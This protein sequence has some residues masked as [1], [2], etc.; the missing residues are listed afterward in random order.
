MRSS[1]A[2]GLDTAKGL[3][4]A[5]QIPLVGVNHMQAHALTP[6]L[7]S[8]LA[9]VPG[10]KSSKT[11]EFPF[12]SLLVSGGHTL[13]LRSKS[14]TEHR[15]LANTIDIAVGDLLDK[16]ARAVCPPSVFARKPHE[17]MYGRLLEEFAFPQQQH[18]YSYG[19]REEEAS[20]RDSR[21][22]WSLPIPFARD[23]SAKSRAMDFSFTGLGSAVES[24]AAGIE[25]R[26]SGTMSVMNADGEMEERV[27][28]AREAMRVTFEH[29][30]SRVVGALNSIRTERPLEQD[31]R[32]IPNSIQM[33]TEEEKQNRMYNL[34]VSGGVASNQYLRTMYVVH[35][36]SFPL[37]HSLF[38][39]GERS[40]L[41]ISTITIIITPIFGKQSKTIK[42]N[43]P[44]SPLWH[45]FSSSKPSHFTNPP[46][47]LLFFGH[48]K[49][50]RFPRRQRL[51]RCQGS[52]PPRRPLHRQRGHDRL[53][54]HRDVRRRMGELFSGRWSWWWWWWWWGG[55]GGGTKSAMRRS[56][57]TVEQMECGCERGRRGDFGRGRVD[58]E[59][60]RER[61]SLGS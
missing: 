11:P 29:L 50:P 25:Q 39:E 22:G 26:A 27:E 9:E 53:D 6:R 35:T 14:I 20:R 36:F 12:L 18:E 8:A 57:K 51:A 31:E 7:V 47:P 17:I 28:L 23:G 13:V 45:I 30:A 2:I 52:L 34:V 56:G 33:K 41:M 49:S 32:F 46:P 15:I 3:A 19:K 24:I 4:V 16:I 37:L 1:L 40:L 10:S 54:G 44:S 60:E 48:Q 21:F 5:W 43:P 61:K 59:R 42:K 58:E 55:G 38:A